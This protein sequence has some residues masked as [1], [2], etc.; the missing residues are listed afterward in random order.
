MRRLRFLAACLVLAVALLAP[1]PA[2]ADARTSGP[3][4]R[5]DNR[6]TPLARAE[7]GEVPPDRLVTVAPGC[8]V[9]REAGPSLALL[10]RL[11]SASG[12]GLGT[13]DCYRPVDEQVAVQGAWTARGNSACAATPQRHPD[14]RPKGTSM[15]GWGKAT[16]FSNAGGAMTFTSTGYRFLKSW[17]A[18]LG[19]NH[20]GWAEPGGST[21]PEPWHWEWV[22]DGGTTGGTP[23][24][25]DVVAL[26]PGPG[27]DGHLA[28][29][30]LG[31]VQP[32]GA[33]RSAGSAEA[34]PLNWVI[35]S[36]AGTPDRAGY[37]LLGGDGGIFTYGT[38]RFH[39][40]TGAMRLNSPIVGMA[41]APD[42][43]GY[44]L[45]A[46][47]GG[48]FTFGSARF[49]GSTG[50]MRL[51]SPIVGMAAAPDG[52]GY[53]LVAAD[54]GVFTFGRAPFHGSAADR[55]LVAPTVALVPAGGDAGYWLVAADGTVVTRGKAEHF[56]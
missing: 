27:D 13:R 53:W 7:N 8:R 26:L 30:G 49:H 9:A 28:V 6:P 54:G 56:G 37:W 42:G 20:P 29:T 23:V 55:G 40:S 51:N 45:V 15:H 14:G 32:T 2:P 41:A 3:S 12:V 1:A 52:A 33:A 4:I 36:A 24:R 19:W 48:V 25:A 43:A 11:A 50:A 5:P 34:V 46:A 39:G 31:A 10:F 21:C 17:A 35:V 16:D 44:W 47:D 22:G 38:A 18:R